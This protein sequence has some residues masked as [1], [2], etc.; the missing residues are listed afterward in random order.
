[1]AKKLLFKRN[2]PFFSI[3]CE[4]DGTGGSDNEH[5]DD[6]SGDSD[7]QGWVGGW[8]QYWRI[9]VTRKWGMRGRETPSM[10]WTMHQSKTRCTRERLSPNALE[11]NSEHQ[12]IVSNA[13]GLN[14]LQHSWAHGA[15]ALQKKGWEKFNFLSWTLEPVI[16]FK[17]NTGAITLSL[18]REHLNWMIALIT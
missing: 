8:T 17:K 10:C 18:S 2:I 12:C 14:A 1:M 4:D 13:P 15:V 16:S 6:K 7:D 3:I 11:H 5:D 9:S